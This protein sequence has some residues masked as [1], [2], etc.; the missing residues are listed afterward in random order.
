VFSPHGGWSKAAKQVVA[1][2]NYCVDLQLT[3]RS[4]GKSVQRKAEAVIYRDWDGKHS[5][6]SWEW[7]KP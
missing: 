5:L 6:T 3:D 7:K 1:G 2:M 4:S